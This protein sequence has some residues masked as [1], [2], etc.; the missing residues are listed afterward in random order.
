MKANHAHKIV[1]LKVGIGFTEV[2]VKRGQ[3]IFGRNKA[4]DALGIDGSTIYKHLQK[5]EEWGNISID[6]N[7]QYSIVTICKYDEYQDAYS[8]E[9]QPSSS[10]VTTK[11]Q[12]S[13]SRVTQTRSYNNDKNNKNNK[14]NTNSESLEMFERFRV[15]YAG[16]KR[17]LQTE[18]DD[19]TKKHKDWESALPMLENAIITQTQSRAEDAKIGKFVPQ[20]KNMKTW[21]NQRCWEEVN[22]A[23]PIKKTEEITE[24]Q[25]YNY[26]DYEKACKIRKIEPKPQNQT[27]FA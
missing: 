17:G 9:E 15:L 7:N 22:G 18:F 21:I 19:F 14:N 26:H 13:S 12:Q 2:E 1:P 25:Y 5:L 27:I 16:K 10:Q 23:E 24:E 3:F 20:W 11:E 8:E 6:S 4:E